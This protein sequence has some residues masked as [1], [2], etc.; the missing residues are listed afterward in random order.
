MITNI[1]SIEHIY[2]TSISFLTE[3]VNTLDLKAPDIEIVRFRLGE[4]VLVSLIII[5][6]IRLLKVL[7]EF[8]LFQVKLSQAF[9]II[10][11]E[12]NMA[13]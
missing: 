11:N 3:Q 10:I 6:F 5:I 7:L 4:F 1:L 12:V 8:F 2:Y 13:I 9:G